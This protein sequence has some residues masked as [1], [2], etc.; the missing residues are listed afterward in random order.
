MRQTIYS[1]PW[2]LDFLD[3]VV[4]QTA[5]VKVK[6][7]VLKWNQSQITR[8]ARF[9]PKPLYTYKV[10]GEEELPPLSEHIRLL[11]VQEVR[12][13]CKAGQSFDHKA[14]T[15]MSQVSRIICH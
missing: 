10:E 4:P 13:E 2:S 9:A 8:A 15:R 1:M 12:F 11:S 14:M 5:T 3:R 7:L 6:H